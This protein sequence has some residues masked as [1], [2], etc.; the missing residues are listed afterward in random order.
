[1]ISYFF[2]NKL[3]VVCAE[4]KHKNDNCKHQKS[5][6]DSFVLKSL[7]N[8]SGKQY[9]DTCMKYG[10]PNQQLLIELRRLDYQIQK[11][12]NSA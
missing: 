3:V 5:I 1:M 9:D 7:K 4:C 8:N 2:N 12:K 11:V 6:S 10:E